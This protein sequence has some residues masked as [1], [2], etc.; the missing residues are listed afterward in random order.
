ME[1]LMDLT[2]EENGNLKDKV[3]MIKRKCSVCYFLLTK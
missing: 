3:G 1:V 2:K